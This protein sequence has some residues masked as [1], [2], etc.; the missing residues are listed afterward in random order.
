MDRCDGVGAIYQFWSNL[1]RR[2]TLHRNPEVGPLLTGNICRFVILVLDL[3]GCSHVA[4]PV[5]NLCKTWPF[6]WFG[7]PALFH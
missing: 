5:R 2:E 6:R 7:C 1:V 4:Q 3:V